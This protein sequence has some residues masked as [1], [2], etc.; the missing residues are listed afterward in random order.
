MHRAAIALTMIFACLVLL[1]AD[2]FAR[3]G[4]GG[5]G[6]GRGGGVGGGTGGRTGGVGRT[7]RNR[8][9]QN[10]TNRTAKDLAELQNAEDRLEHIKER[11]Q[12]LVDDA[13]KALMEARSKQQRVDDV[14]RLADPK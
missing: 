5:G 10:R 9:R 12:A 7:G 11:R 8:G 14:D 6:G 4:R 2:S 3:G 13:R 1:T